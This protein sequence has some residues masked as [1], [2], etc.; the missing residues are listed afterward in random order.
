MAARRIVYGI[1]LAGAVAFYWASRNWLSAVLLITAV[2]LPWLSLILSLPAILQ[3]K[4]SLQCPGAVSIGVPAKVSVVVSCRFPAPP[5][6]GKLRLWVLATGKKRRIKPGTALPTDHCGA[7]RLQCSHLWTAD[8]LGLIRVP[9][10]LRENRLVLVRPMAILP[11]Q[12][13][14]VSR[15]L[16]NI[17][18]PKPGGGYA[19]NHE[20]REY[21]PG[22]N[23]RQIHWKLSAKT[24]DLIVREPMEAEQNAVHLTMEL[25]GAPEVLDRKLG[26]LLGMSSYLAE[27]NIKHRILCYTGKGMVDLGISNGQESVDAIDLLLQQPLAAEEEIPVY[28]KSL[29]RHHIGGG[30]IET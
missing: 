26:Q 8:Y 21:R 20:L 30:G 11:E 4:V 12:L 16:C 2:C 10:R 15:Y 23:L 9:V 22:D 7:Y 29:W 6:S 3:C 28:P 1:A 17:T 14:D 25:S 13:P 24:G 19:E 27:N 5:V 18:R